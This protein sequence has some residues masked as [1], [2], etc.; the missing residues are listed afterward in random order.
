MKVKGSYMF[1]NIYVSWVPRWL[2]EHKAMRL[3]VQ[4]FSEGPASVNAMKL[5]SV[6]IILVDFLISNQIVIKRLF[7]Y[8]T[9]IY[10]K[11]ALSVPSGFTL[12]LFKCQNFV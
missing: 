12:Q 10:H 6:I 7:Q 4:T 2:S 5:T 1:L 8:Q 9:I 3:S 11:L